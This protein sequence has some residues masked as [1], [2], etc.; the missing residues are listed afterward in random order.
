MNWLRPRWSCS[1][2][3]WSPFRLRWL[4]KVTTVEAAAVIDQRLVPQLAISS[5]KLRL[6]QRRWSTTE[7]GTL[8]SATHHRSNRN[9]H[10]QHPRLIIG[11]ATVANIII[12]TWLMDTLN[13]LNLWTVIQQL[14]FP[15]HY[16]IH[17]K[18]NLNSKYLRF[19][20]LCSIVFIF[21]KRFSLPSWQL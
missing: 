16:F 18:K 6:R 1:S 3:S 19:V 8:Q 12:T 9:G 21:I 13:T 7:Q 2:N 20:L 14:R 10:S 5:N 17:S 11:A 15:K 4:I